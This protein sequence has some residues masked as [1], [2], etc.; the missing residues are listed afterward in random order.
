MAN[1]IFH[2]SIPLV[3]KKIAVEK[4]SGELVVDATQF[5]RTLYFS[6]GKLMFVSCNSG[7]FRLGDILVNTGKINLKEYEEIEGMLKTDDGKIGQVLARKKKVS[8]RDVFLALLYQVRSLG[9]SSF[10]VGYGEWEFFKKT[11][12]IP[13][14]SKFEVELPNIIAEGARKLE[15]RSYFKDHLQELSPQVTEIPAD[16]E[17]F[18]TR[19]EI[20]FYHK[21]ERFQ[22]NSNREIAMAL[23]LD[24]EAY[25]ERIV[26][27]F[28]LGIIDF[29]ELVEDE[30]VVPNVDE[31]LRLYDFLK[32]GEIDYY[33]LL[34]IPRTVGFGEIKK[35]YLQA[36][37]LHH[38]DSLPGD[39]DA[40]IMQKA[41]FVFL[42]INNAYEVL[43]DSERRG[44]YD[45]KGIGLLDEDTADNESELQARALYAEA[46]GL[47]NDNKHWD[48]AHVLEKV[49]ELDNTRGIYFFRLGL[50][51]ARF[52]PLKRSAEAR[53]KKAA[54]MEPWNADPV[55]A[56]GILYKG[57]NHKDMSE[58][59]F[60]KALEI[61]IE[62]TKAAKRVMEIER[63][64]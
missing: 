39:T 47:I 3:F 6:N 10:T 44:E 48:A 40:D 20:N 29:A 27:F 15:D 26:L 36:S 38:P 17:I 57:M 60:R 46:L 50:C 54:E 35:A 51:Q 9:V 34:G 2:H 4:L 62:H 52:S 63:K 19:A 24:E 45:V 7:E 43:S 25:W 14:N 49:V 56:L 64:K 37:R 13:G 8:G 12:A 41:D 42:E 21:L 59:C 1:E 11:P 61:N 23:H 58:T 30:D 33:Q 18:L 55:Y 32:N 31:T 28:L 5:K 16:Y 22:S 53:L